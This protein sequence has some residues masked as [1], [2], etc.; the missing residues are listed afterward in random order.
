MTQPYEV[1]ILMYSQVFAESEYEK[2]E[3]AAGKAFFASF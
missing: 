2:E 1:E 3:V